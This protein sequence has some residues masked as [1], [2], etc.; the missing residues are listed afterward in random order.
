MQIVIVV[1]ETIVGDE[2]KTRLTI[3]LYVLLVILKTAHANRRS[4]LSLL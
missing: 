2:L 3:I 1:A 4:L